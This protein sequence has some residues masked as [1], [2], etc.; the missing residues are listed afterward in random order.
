[1][2]QGVPLVD[3]CE[4]GCDCEPDED[5]DDA[6]FYCNCECECVEEPDLEG[7]DNVFYEHN[8]SF[9]KAVE[10]Y[11]NYKMGVKEN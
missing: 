11:L 8:N 1:M 6:D 3:F 9:V 4:Y 5:G 7:L 2:V 10:A